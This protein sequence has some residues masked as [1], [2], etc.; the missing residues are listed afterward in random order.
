MVQKMKSNIGIPTK[1]PAKTCSDKKC[2]FHGKLSVHGS[3]FTGTVVSAKR[4]NTV[5]VEW[6]RR[7]ML[8][9]YE[10]Y[11][12]RKTKISVH[13]PECI[14][15]KEGDM[16]RIMSCKPL[17]KT[18]NFVVIENL[19]HVFGFEERMEAISASKVKEKLKKEADTVN[20]EAED[21]KKQ[22]TQEGQE[23]LEN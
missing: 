2:P 8:P 18:K 17:S 12:R 13:N 16:V 1:A 23:A 5:S 3:I 19:G 11:E 15:A 21:T 22:E 14:A 6:S 7:H 20:A 4:H 10:R 9:K